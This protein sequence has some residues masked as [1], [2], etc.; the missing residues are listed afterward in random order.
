LISPFGKDPTFLEPLYD[1]ENEI[2]DFLLVNYAAEGRVVEKDVL[3]MWLRYGI[4]ILKTLDSAECV[5]GALCY[6]A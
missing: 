5:W 2:V 1:F 3:E 6:S 4:M